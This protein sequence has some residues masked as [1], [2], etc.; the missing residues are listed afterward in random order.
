[1]YILSANFQNIKPAIF[2]YWKFSAIH[3]LSLKR[4]SDSGIWE[5]L[6]VRYDKQIWKKLAANERKFFFNIVWE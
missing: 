2:L 5:K 1:M 6:E 3:C 4:D